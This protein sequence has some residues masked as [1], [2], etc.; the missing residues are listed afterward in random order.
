LIET[1]RAW[2]AESHP[3]RTPTSTGRR[4]HARPPARTDPVTR[5][6]PARP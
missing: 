6:G 1:D 2:R 4:P 5:P 3:G